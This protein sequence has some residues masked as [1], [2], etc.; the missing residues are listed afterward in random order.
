M[1]L[2]SEIILEHFKNPKNFGKLEKAQKSELGKNTSC[3]DSIFLELEIE[4]GKIK[5]IAFSGQ[6]CA[7]SI[8]AMSMLSEKI[9]GLSL[10]EID[11]L[12]QNFIKDLLK[13]DIGPG[14]IKCAMLGLETLKK[15]IKDA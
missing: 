7:I 9:K 8:A 5:D 6:G 4:D 13:I 1:D 14:R 10:N 15:A 2:Y 12:D 11:S 3:G